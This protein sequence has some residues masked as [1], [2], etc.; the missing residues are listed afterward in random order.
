MLRGFADIAEK[1]YRN[2]VIIFG[3]VDVF[4]NDHKKIS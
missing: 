1:I 4:K 3:Y 2:D